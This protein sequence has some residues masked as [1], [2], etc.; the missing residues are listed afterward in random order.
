MQAASSLKAAIAS[1]EKQASLLQESIRQAGQSSEFA[2]LASLQ[3]KKRSLSSRKS[4][5][6]AELLGFF[7]PIDKP[8]KRFS[9]LVSAKKAFL[10]NTEQEAILSAML[11]DAVL[12]VKKDPNG[13]TIKEILLECKKAIES[14]ALTLKEKEKQKKI[15]AL[16]RLLATNF[17]D[18]FFWK[19]NETE[20]SAN[21]IEK[22]LSQ[23]TLHKTISDEKQRL[24]ALE[25]QLE[26]A[27]IE[28]LQKEHEQQKKHEIV[29]VL[30]QKLEAS[31]KSA[32]NKTVTVS[33][34]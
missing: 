6:N 31:L 1:L 2:A 16:N 8:L 22:K 33:V 34:E 23:S 9:A 7:S 27:K 4:E 11:N 30:T 28:R 10:K 14:N 3:E 17:F 19:L 5:L 12:A 21:E 15:D 32:L 25:K 18:S 24:S 20:A 26:Q 29:A 13:E